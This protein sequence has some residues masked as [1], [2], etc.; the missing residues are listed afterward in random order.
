MIALVAIS[1]S[2][3][4]QVGIKG[5]LGLGFAYNK[6]NAGELQ[7]GLNLGANYAFNESIRAEF[8]I[9][10]IFNGDKVAGTKYTSTILPVTVGAEYLLLPSSIVHPYAGLNLGLYHFGYKVNKSNTTSNHFGFA[11]KVGVDI[12]VMDNLSIDV[13]AKFHMY[14][15]EDFFDDMHL[16]NIFGVN[17][18]VVYK[19]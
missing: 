18:G 16:G 5:G 12:A 1:T 19:F 14:L 4:S 17:F 3:N 13:C 6:D 10:P 2:A 15:Y 8:L 11:P 9:G 7:V